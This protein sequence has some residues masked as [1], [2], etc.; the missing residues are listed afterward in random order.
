MSF[1][2]LRD[3]DVKGHRVFLRADLNVPLKDGVI[4]NSKRIDATL[5]TLKHLLDGGASVVLCSHLGRPAGAGFEAEFSLAPVAAWLKEKNGID[6][7]LAS[8]VV[9]GASVTNVAGN[10]DGTRA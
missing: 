9:G 3:I 4:T 8:G 6:V 2:T 10:H 1:L 5:P 7:R